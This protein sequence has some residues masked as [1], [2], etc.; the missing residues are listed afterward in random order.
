[1]SNVLGILRTTVIKISLFFIL[2]K[3]EKGISDILQHV[4]AI[5]CTLFYVCDFGIYPCHFVPLLAPNPG[6]AIASLPLLS[7][8]WRRGVVVTAFVAWTKL[9]HVGPG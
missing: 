2:L 9:T 5:F 1:M 8:G 4:A 6:D 3:K 7:T